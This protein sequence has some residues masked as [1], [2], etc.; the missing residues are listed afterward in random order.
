[1]VSRTAQSST[2][3]GASSTKKTEWTRSS[4][5]DIT[6]RLPLSDINAS[7]I[8]YGTRRR[9]NIDY[10]ISHLNGMQVKVKR[11]SSNTVEKRIKSTAKI[12][13]QSKM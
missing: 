12:T 5:I 3:S 8:I 7:N 2:A 1:M 4:P 6:K 13:K 10:H 11:N 9:S